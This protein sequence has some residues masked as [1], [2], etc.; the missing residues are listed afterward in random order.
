MKRIII[1]TALLL[2]AI[3]SLPFLISPQQNAEPPK[4]STE[5]INILRLHFSEN[6]VALENL[7]L[8][9]GRAKLQKKPTKT[10]QLYFEQRSLQGELLAHGTI[11][12]PRIVFYDTANQETG[13][14]EGG[15]VELSEAVYDLRVPAHNRPSLITLTDYRTQQSGELLLKQQLPAR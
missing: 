9:P 13:K 5:Q 6:G 1:V 8:K 10:R 14:L 3:A 15:S 11:P 7:G 2:I 4:K 12:D